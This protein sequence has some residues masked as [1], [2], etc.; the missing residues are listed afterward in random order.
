[1]LKLK[2][3]RYGFQLFESSG[4]SFSEIVKGPTKRNMISG[5]VGSTVGTEY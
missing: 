5:K 3:V 1:M 4:A 2:V